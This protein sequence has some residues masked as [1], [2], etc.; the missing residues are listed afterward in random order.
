MVKKTILV[1][2]DVLRRLDL[3]K[4][5][6]AFKSYSETLR[7]ILA[8]TKTLDKPEQGTLPTLKPF[9]RENSES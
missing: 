6:K 4:R 2:I 1:D 7:D 5:E 9:V 8:Q 3:I